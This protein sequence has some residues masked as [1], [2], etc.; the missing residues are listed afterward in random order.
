MSRRNRQS[1]ASTT[2]ISCADP[3][4]GLAQRRSCGELSRH[5]LQQ[6]EPHAPNVTA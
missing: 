3:C 6:Q 4:G 2:G 5:L 1:P